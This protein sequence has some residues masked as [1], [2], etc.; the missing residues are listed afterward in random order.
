MLRKR[1][2]IEITQALEVTKKLD[3]FPKLEDDYKETSS[4]RGT[5]KFKLPFLYLNEL[6]NLNTF[7]SC[8]HCFYDNSC[9]GAFRNQILLY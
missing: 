6:S 2:N 9:P 4:T 3:V 1:R 8:Y 7:F 5:C